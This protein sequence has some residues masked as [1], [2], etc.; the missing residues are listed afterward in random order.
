MRI[1]RRKDR[2]LWVRVGDAEFLVCPLSATESMRLHEKHTKVRVKRGQVIEHTD[3]AA[4]AA[5]YFDRVVRDW[6]PLLDD[7]GKP[8]P[9]T[10]IVDEETGEQV[11]CTP[12]EKRALW[13]NDTDLAA[14]IL[15]AI[16]DEIKAR[17]EGA[18][19]N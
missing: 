14:E 18:E 5:E 8:I 9:G 1:R 10:G 16:E 11:P 15:E 19:K 4:F 7:E 17:R 2:E 12:A 6:R 3:K 13:D